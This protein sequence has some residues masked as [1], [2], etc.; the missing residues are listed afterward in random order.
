METDLL[1]SLPVA[2]EI[3]EAMRTRI[4]ELE[5]ELAP[6][7]SMKR[8]RTRIAPDVSTPA[9]AG[10]SAASIKMDERKRKMQVKKARILSHSLRIV[11][12]LNPFNLKE[13]KSD[14]V[15]FQDFPQVH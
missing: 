6:Q 12:S 15:K 14:V 4:I 5:D 2:L 13:C 9:A 1:S 10:P 3:L 7:P 8:A 11:R